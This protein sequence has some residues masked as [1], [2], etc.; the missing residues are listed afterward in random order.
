MVSRS[1][2]LGAD[3]PV[4]ETRCVMKYEQLECSYAT[5]RLGCLEP[6]S[7]EFGWIAGILDDVASFG[8][9][10]NDA[11]LCITKRSGFL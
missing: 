4:L 1:Q 5:Q 3:G 11:L 2:I 9:D 10:G 6:S 8:F 7:W